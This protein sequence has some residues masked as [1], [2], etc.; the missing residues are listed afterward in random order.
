MATKKKGGGGKLSRSMTVTVRLDPKLRFAAE[1]AAR[2][3]R[4]TVSSLIEWAIEDSLSRYS[5]YDGGS[6]SGENEISTL[7]VANDI[8]DVDEADRLIKIALATPELLTYEEQ[9]L[10]KLVQEEFGTPITRESYNGEWG[11]GYPKGG[12][13][14]KDLRV[15]WETFK[16]VASGE[17]E[18]DA[19]PTRAE[20]KYQ[21]PAP[22]KDVPDFDDDIP[23]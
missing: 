19:L 2:K 8:W 21:Q 18:E 1:L 23:F 12:Q 16:K 22:A 11:W 6:Y 14:I 20:K 3:Q 7:D 4:R 10:W 13:L 5:L 15:H 9:I 17:L